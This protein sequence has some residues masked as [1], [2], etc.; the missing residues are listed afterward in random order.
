MTALG[1]GSCGIVIFVAAKGIRSF[2]PPGA[3]WGPR[4]E[5]PHRFLGLA[6]PRRLAQD[7]QRPKV[8][9][10]VFV[11]QATGIARLGIDLG[12]L[13]FRGGSQFSDPQRATC[14]TVRCTRAKFKLCESVWQR[15]QEESS[16]KDTAGA[17]ER[18]AEGVPG[19]QRAEAF[20]L[21]ALY[22]CRMSST[23]IGFLKTSVLLELELHGA[24]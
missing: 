18:L 13:K 3:P 22:R 16:R 20:A 11:R 19:L 6:T 23:G 15:C 12:P 4:P 1:C 9:I 21:L 2:L 10:T 8:A 24:V 14:A 17:P 5:V 7:V